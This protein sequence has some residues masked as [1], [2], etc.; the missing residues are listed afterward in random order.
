MATVLRWLLSPHRRDILVVLP[1]VLSISVF[2][3]FMASAGTFRDLEGMKRYASMA[4]GFEHGHLYLRRRPPPQ[5]LA[6][7]DPLYPSNRSLWVWDGSLY[8][9]RWYF[10]WGPVP[11]LLLVAVDKL[12][13]LGP[14]SDQTLTLIF[15]L[16]RL[17]GGAALIIGLSRSALA[18][19]QPP[20]LVGLAVAVFGLTSPIPFILC[21]PNVYEACLAAGQCFLF[22]GLAFALWG[23][24]RPNRRTLLFVVSSV[25]WGLA[26]GSRVTM[27][28]PIPL[29]IVITLGVLW[30]GYDRSLGTLL[31]HAFALGAPAA[32]AVMA[33]AAYNYARF[34]SVTEFGTTWQAS[35]QKFVTNRVF[36]LPNLYSYLFA[37]VLWSCRFPFVMAVSRRPLASWIEWPPDYATFE[38]MGGLLLLSGWCWLLMVLPFRSMLGMWKRWRYRGLASAEKLRSIELWAMLC[39]LAIA[40]SM[41]PVLGLWEASMRYTGDAIGGLVIAATLAAFWCKRRADATRKPCWM[42]ATRGALIGLGLYTCI[43]GAFSGVAS[44]GE[45]FKKHNPALYE[46]LQRNWSLC[47]RAI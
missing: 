24:A 33:Y 25:C 6:Q 40:M 15:M 31:R 45:P 14:V 1:I 20:W 44:Y 29:I 41:V 8:E 37:P 10:Y 13:R 17:Y 2:Y 9:N 39:A 42:W 30:L 38:P 4:D 27:A 11:A 18:R 3:E 46:S 19:G 43:I 12:T 28:I 16:G 21:R 34:D 47:A 22:I 5:L 26:I 36:F 7:E 23:L 35:T 32:F